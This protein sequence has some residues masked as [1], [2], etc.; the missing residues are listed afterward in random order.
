[1]EKLSDGKFVQS[2]WISMIFNR[3]GLS[4]Q[5]LKWLERSFQTHDQDL[6]YLLIYDD[7]DK[8]HGDQRFQAIKE[9][10]QLPY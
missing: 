1:L 2:A 5:A 7:F 10:M 4:D 6:P 9:K 3:A 8:L